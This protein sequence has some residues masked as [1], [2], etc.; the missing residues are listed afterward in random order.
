MGRRRRLVGLGFCQSN[1]EVVDLGSAC[2]TEG[3][4]QAV[5]SS[6][7]VDAWQ[8]HA[9]SSLGHPNI[10]GVQGPDGALLSFL[11]SDG[12]YEVQK[13]NWKRWQFN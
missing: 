11:L 6:V 2:V 5:V 4:V 3:H 7:D 1:W 8:S 10:C 13:E 12:N 9:S